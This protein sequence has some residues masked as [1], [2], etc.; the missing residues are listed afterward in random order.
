MSLLR[1]EGSGTG[2]GMG[3]PCVICHTDF[4]VPSDWWVPFYAKRS[5]TIW[6][7][8]PHQTLCSDL[9]RGLLFVSKGGTHLCLMFCSHYT[10]DS[11][12]RVNT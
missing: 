7:L 10:R 8:V 3:S 4:G 5:E 2:V 6:V 12:C 1:D 9:F 11:E